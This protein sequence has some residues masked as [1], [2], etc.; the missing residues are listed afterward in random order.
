MHK[1]PQLILWYALSL[2]SSLAVAILATVVQTQSKVHYSHLAESVT[3]GSQ[4]GRLIPRLQALFVSQGASI[5]AA[6][7]AAIQEVAG[8]LQLQGYVLAIQDAFRLSVGIIL[9]A[10]I[11]VF[12][13]SGVRRTPTQQAAQP[14]AAEKTLTDE[15]DSARDEAMLA[16]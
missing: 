13:V 4:L 15:A 3:S 9:V 14:V 16:V 10:I 8:L 1:P 12:F 7:A 11:A 2:S 5:D 6:R